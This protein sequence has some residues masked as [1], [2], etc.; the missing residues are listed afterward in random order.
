MPRTSFA[1]FVEHWEYLIATVRSNQ[2]ELAGLVDL[3]EQLEAEFLNAGADALYYVETVYNDFDITLKTSRCNPH[4][5]GIGYRHID[6]DEDNGFRVTSEM[7]MEVEGNAR[8]AMV[9]ETLS[10]VYA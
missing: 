5:V 3:C 9:A 6:F 2:P 10:I 8:P 1:D 7:T 4:R